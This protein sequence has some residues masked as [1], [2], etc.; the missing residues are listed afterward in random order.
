[1]ARPALA[2]GTAGNIC[3]TKKATRKWV[4]RCRYRD[5]SGRIIW[6][7]RTADT[8]PASERRVKEAVRDHVPSIPGGEIT[9]DTRLVDLGRAWLAEY[10]KDAEKDYR[11]WGTIDTYR[12]RLEGIIIPE[13]GQLRIFEATTRTLEALCSSVRDKSSVSSAKTVRSILSGMF[14]FAVK[15]DARESNPVREIAALENRKARN[16]RTAPRALTQDEALDLLAK[17]DADEVARQQDLPDLVRF[18]LA[19]GERTGEAL[20]AHWPDFLPEQKLIRMS[21]NVIRAKG[22]GKMINPG[23]TENSDR[24]IPL[25]DWGVDMLVDRKRAATS[26]DGPIF[27]STTGT[28]REASNVRNRAWNPF[29]KRAGYGWVT[30]RT[31]RKTV[32]TLLDD[33]GL[34]ARQIAD[35]LG[36]ARP[37]MTQDVYMGRGQISRAGAEALGTV[38]G[39]PARQDVAVFVG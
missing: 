39:P 11:S 19:T 8:R 28:I 21:G 18:F 24:D 33:A 2:I 36:H 9:R 15:H 34:T 7:E 26:L 13:I 29:A 17:L 12:S 14:A 38:L 27:P 16:K 35:I 31:F 37:S 6:L 32:A 20:G 5:Y 1:M 4:A 30:F 25:T 10:E 22:K 23:K 3:Y